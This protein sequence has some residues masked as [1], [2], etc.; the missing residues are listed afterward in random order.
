MIDNYDSFTYN[1]VQYCLELGATPKVIRNDELTLSEIVALNPSQIIISPG[2]CT[3]NE[4]GVSL[5][6]VSH[7]YKTIPLLGVCLG[8]QALVQAL[9][10]RVIRAHLVMHG[11]TSPVL[12]DQSGVFA[13]LP[14]PLVAT[15]YHSLVADEQDLPAELAVNAWVE[16]TDGHRTIM[17]VQHKTYPVAGV[18]FHPESIMSEC[19]HDMLANFLRW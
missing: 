10:G 15:R 9:G 8:H 11:K 7:F 12:H 17:G 14:S 5:E 19:G 13:N 6:V 1:L 16:E 3:P 2:P 18:Q 4:A